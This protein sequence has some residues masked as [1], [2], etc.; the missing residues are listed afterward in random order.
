MKG[1]RG[2]CVRRRALALVILVAFQPAGAALA[3]TPPSG[4]GR[5]FAVAVSGY[6]SPKCTVDTS[7]GTNGAF[8][9]ILDPKTGRAAAETIDLPFAMT[10]NTPF[11]AAL[12]SKNGGLILSGA[13]EPR[14][15]SL[16]GY[17][18]SLGMGQ[19]AGGVTLNCDSAE[20]RAQGSADEPGSACHA[21]S[22]TSVRTS[23]GDG[24]VRL[25]LKP[26]NEPLLKGGYSDE[27]ILRIS[28]TVS[29]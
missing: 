27:L 13:S 3:I 2:A 6:I 19:I 28:P 17:S 18:A 26:G 15:A 9:D 24:R 21:A 4:A 23:S 12:V 7:Q 29:G 22:A 16:V 10:C 5:S 20:M 8:G 11:V 1:D 14:F 25:R